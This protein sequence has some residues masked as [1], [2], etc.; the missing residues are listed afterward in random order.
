MP[1]TVSSFLKK[2]YIPLTCNRYAGIA[3]QGDY[4][5]DFW[6]WNGQ[7]TEK[8]GARVI[9]S[10][11]VVA[12][13]EAALRY[14][15]DRWVPL[16]PIDGAFLQRME[17]A[18]RS[19]QGLKREGI[20]FPDAPFLEMPEPIDAALMGPEVKRYLGLAAD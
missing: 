15:R 3:W 8:E 4:L 1:I 2:G 20:I 9:Q 19:H 14:W 6:M 11:K 5:H 13:K 10:V 7:F 12:L 17:G 18:L 16:K